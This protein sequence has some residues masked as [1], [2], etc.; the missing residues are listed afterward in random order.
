[1]HRVAEEIAGAYLGPDTIARALA[2]GLRIGESLARHDG[3]GFFGALGDSVVTGATLTNVN[4]VRIV[5]VTGD[6]G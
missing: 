3:H 1:M 4:D 6:G 2:R 5:L